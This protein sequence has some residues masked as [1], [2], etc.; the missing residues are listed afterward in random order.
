MGGY[1]DS[2]LGIGVSDVLPAARD[3]WTLFDQPASRPTHKVC[4]K[5]ANCS[6]KKMAGAERTFK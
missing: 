6:C 4:G 5:T 3:L 2:L 1:L